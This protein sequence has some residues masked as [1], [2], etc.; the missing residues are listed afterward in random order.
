[1]QKRILR[2]WQTVIVIR[3]KS[4]DRQEGSENSNAGVSLLDS[5]GG[6]E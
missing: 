2:N 4:V 1:M 3:N 5:I 6:K